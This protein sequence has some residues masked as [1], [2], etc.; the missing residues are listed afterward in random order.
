MA[1]LAT[2]LQRVE[3]G[4]GGGWCPHQRARVVVPGEPMPPH[5]PPCACG[6]PRVAIEVLYVEAAQRELGA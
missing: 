1:S 5:L 6:R 4:L 3:A 2:R